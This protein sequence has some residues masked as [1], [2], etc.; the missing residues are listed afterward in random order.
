MDGHRVD[1]NRVDGHRV[2]GNRVDRPSEGASTTSMA[3]ERTS[4]T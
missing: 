2:G 1:G 3:L 4:Q